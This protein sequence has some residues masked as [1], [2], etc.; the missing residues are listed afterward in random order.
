[1]G[2][3]RY[4]VTATS[5][6]EPAGQVAIVDDTE[7]VHT[8]LNALDDAD[9]RAILDVTDRKARSA[10]ELSELCNLPMS[11][12]YRKLEMLVEANLLVERTRIRRSGKGKHASE[13]ARAVEEVLVS[14]GREAELELMVFQREVADGSHE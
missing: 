8:L 14:V 11:T 13:Y 6:E 7:G 10:R 4:S 2:Q 9:C 1:M 12:V 5:S 3:S